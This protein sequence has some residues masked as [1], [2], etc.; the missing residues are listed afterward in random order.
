MMLIRRSLT[1][2]LILALLLTI[3]RMAFAQEAT[4]E[5]LPVEFTETPTSEPTIIPTDTPTEVPT[6]LPTD[7]PALTS[8]PSETEAPTDDAVEPTLIFVPSPTSTVQTFP[9]EPPLA[10]LFSD[11][12]DSAASAAWTLSGNW[13][14]GDGTLKLVM[15]GGTA[16]LPLSPAQDVA[17]Q[18]RVLLSEGS[19]VQISLQDSGNGGYAALLR[20]DGWVGLYRAGALLQIAQVQPFALGD[21]HALR[22]SAVGGI[23][24][25]SV[26]ATE[27][28]A[29]QDTAALSPGTMNLIGFSAGELLIDDMAVWVPP[30]QLPAPTVVPS[31]TLMPT[32][33]SVVPTPEVTPVVTAEATKLPTIAPPAP[34]TP[35]RD[36]PPARTR[37]S[38]SAQGVTFVV[39]TTAD[40]PNLTTP[41]NCDTPE[42]LCTL[43]AAIQR[44]DE[45]SGAD[46][47]TFNIPSSGVQ[48]IVLQSKLTISSSVILDGTTQPG[49]T[50][51]PLMQLKPSGSFIGSEGIQ[52]LNSD[53][54]FDTTLSVT[55]RGLA[56][57]GFDTG[58]DVV[59]GQN[60][61]IEQNYIGIAPDGLTAFPNINGLIFNAR[62]SIIR[63]NVISGNINGGL[64]LRSIGPYLSINNN[65]TGN[66]IGTNFS[67]T[68]AIP[69]QVG[70]EITYGANNNTIGGTTP[71]DR[72]LISG[73]KQNG[74]SII[75]NSDPTLDVT[76][77]VIQGNFIGTNAVGNAKLGNNSNGIYI[78]QS[79]GNTVGGTTGTT[80]GGACT[81]AC[82]LISGNQYGINIFGNSGPVAQGNTI[83]G[84]YIGTDSTGI[85]AVPNS[86]GGLLIRGNDNVIGGTSSAARNVISGNGGTGIGF[87]GTGAFNNLVLGNYIGTDTTGNAPLG[88]KGYGIF[89]FNAAF[90]NKIGNK[91]GAGANR[92]AY[93]G[94]LDNKAG[95]GI[96]EFALNG[97][98]SIHNQIATN[99]LYDNKGLGIDLLPEGVTP[100]DTGD[101]DNGTN[102]R[103]NFPTLNV[104]TQATTVI[105]GTLNSKPNKA[106]QIEVYTNSACDP[107]GYGEGESSVGLVD[108]MTDANGNATFSV[109]VGF[110]LPG[111]TGITAIA[112]DAAGNTSEFSACK[113]ALADLAITNT[114]SGTPLQGAPLTYTVEVKNQAGGSDAPNTVVT[115]PLPAQVTFV[116]AVSSQ[117][118]CGHN[119]ANHTVTCDLG[120]LTSGSTAT[121]TITV[122]INTALTVATFTNTAN[123]ISDTPD[124]APG[125]NSAS[126]STT[127][128]QASL[129]LTQT[130]VP[131]PVL[132]GGTLTYIFKT[133]NLGPTTATAIRLHNMLP[134]NVTFV[135]AKAGAGTCTPGNGVVDCTLASLAKGAVWTVT[136]AVSP[137]VG[138]QNT[139]L[140]NTGTIS[141]EQV[142]LVLSNNTAVSK[143]KA[144]ASPIPATPILLSPANAAPTND[145]TPT[146]TWYPALY[147]VGY[148]IQIAA[149]STFT[150][151]LQTAASAV[152][153]YTPSSDLAEGTYYW[154]VRAKNILDVYGLFSAPRAFTVDTTPLNEKAALLTPANGVFV[155]TVRPSFTWKAVT[156]AK[157]YRIQVD[158][159]PQFGSPAINQRVATTSYATPISATPLPQGLYYWQV[160]A[161]D[162]AG[163]E[164]TNWSDPRQFTV[165]IGT[166][167]ANGSFSATGKP[168]FAWAAVTGTTSYSLE[169]ATDNGFTTYVQ[170]YP[171]SLNGTSYTP[172]TPLPSGTLYWRVLRNGEI[173][174]S[175]AYRTLFIGA[176][177]PV[178]LLSFPLNAQLLNAAIQPLS[179]SPVTPPSGVTLKDYEIQLARTAVFT[180]GLITLTS[181]TSDV[182]T[183]ALTDGL[184]YWR[185]R[186]RFSPDALPGVWSAYRRFTIDTAP[187]EP[188]KLSLPTRNSVVSTE[189][190]RF[191]WAVSLTATSYRIDIADNANF[192]NPIANDQT[193][194]TTSYMPAANMTQGHYWW[195]VRAV[196]AATNTSGDSLTGEFTIFIGTA[197]TDG[198]FN[199]TGKPMFTWAAVAGAAGY[200]LEIATDSAFT[201]PVAGYPLPLNKTS[202]TPTTA[203]PNGTL[204]WRVIPNGEIPV[205]PV[206][207]TLFIGAAPAAP[208]PLTPTNAAI[209]HTVTPQLTWSAVTPPS[210]VVLANYEIQLARNSTF[211][212]GLVTLTSGTPDVTT[213]T[214][215][216]GL[217]YWRVRARFGP[218]ALPGTWSAVRY[219][220]VKIP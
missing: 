112:I 34:R 166:A 168:F 44:A 133:T 143:V 159:D 106:Y 175:T 5:A 8:G 70:I 174:A 130:A 189:K 116:S 214:L 89:I 131:N 220:T 145:T 104:V 15:N 140:T 74:I 93:N 91:S 96:D 186:A 149:N 42:L 90:N 21:W 219:F 139:T 191:T 78:Q 177:P 119:P 154:R 71:A 64:L 97:S 98:Y 56:I 171:L 2:L 46:T 17:L 201:N 202:Y 1:A 218:G 118:T 55:I 92:I 85:Q 150:S 80:A 160:L 128:P 41:S 113:T 3:G 115:D 124:P 111:S 192:T 105:S 49:Y 103:Q 208:T 146:L 75:G 127:L 72:N 48:T 176:A 194:T 215:A 19:G 38:L 216:T 62:G 14:A 132:V 61:L 117:G 195:R 164:G 142:D 35:N 57:N 30:D 53:T 50:G 165:F 39:N 172:T 136:I 22:L 29:F 16:N 198:S 51:K 12:F 173:P 58:L 4:P 212:I 94:I 206:Y 43:R 88:N 13:A 27:V 196:D 187:P 137:N 87:S 73:N 65:V 138:T 40:D 107:S 18:L 205:S 81:G 95:I 76:G 217:W 122:T 23:L 110:A 169:I 25:V 213:G 6:A 123:V 210:G 109:D 28:M 100:N 158:D 147:A 178:P 20:S 7:T 200:S 26:D 69:N 33:T 126:Q 209:M 66:Y 125:N 155:S 152:T 182:T 63:D 9:P 120:T 185:V 163:N 183:P 52:I 180:T 101:G 153:S 121:I 68:A 54:S 203:L 83:A 31:P 108:V 32:A 99:E 10:L 167:P 162:P 188:P 129:T 148:E 197:P 45:V 161:I 77:A 67:G 199:A 170:G 135:S 144:N 134:A 36:L 82:N 204:Y 207:R 156:G 11:S 84:N 79:G 24:R 86:S 190:P 157:Q 193:V 114:V 184:W 59:D 60:H 102:E 141:A 47:I 37:P 211:T 181:A 179:W 151:G